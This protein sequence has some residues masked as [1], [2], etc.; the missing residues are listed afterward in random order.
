[1]RGDVDGDPAEQLAVQRDAQ[2][3]GGH[4]AG[5]DEGGAETPGGSVDRVT[6]QP[7]IGT[8]GERGCG[9]RT[10]ARRRRQIE[11]VRGIGPRGLTGR[12]AERHDRPV[13]VDDG[14]D[15]RGQVLR[16]LV[17]RRKAP[18]RAG[19][20]EQGLRRLGL[21]AGLDDGGLGIEGRRGEPGVGL[22]HGTLA[23][24]ERVELGAYGNQVPVVA[25]LRGDVGDEDVL[26]RFGRRLAKR[27][28][29]C[30]PFGLVET[31]GTYETM[32]GGARLDVENELRG[33]D[34]PRG[35][36][37]DPGEHM[38][39]P[40]TR[41][42]FRHRALQFG[43]SG[44]EKPDLHFG[45]PRLRFA[46]LRGV[47]TKAGGAAGIAVGLARLMA[48]VGHREAEELGQRGGHAQPE[49]A[50]LTE[51]LVRR[52]HP[53]LHTALVGP[54]LL[55]R[56]RERRCVEIEEV[57]AA[58]RRPRPESPGPATAPA[59]PVSGWRRRRTGRL[60]SRFPVRLPGRRRPTRAG[61]GAP[62]TESTQP[63]RCSSAAVPRHLDETV[64][65]VQRPLRGVP[66]QIFDEKLRERVTRVPFSGTETASSFPVITMDP[67]H[68]SCGEN[69]QCQVGSKAPGPPGSARTVAGR[70]GQ[71]VSATSL[72]YRPLR[73]QRDGPVV[74]KEYFAFPLPFSQF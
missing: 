48:D 73:L 12:Q 3:A 70:A 27:P 38:L 51:R 58:L 29:H 23:R 9:D 53:Y 26:P 21:A 33:L 1:M 67:L 34:R 36:G 32:G 45:A 10:Q 65:L 18:E 2:G 40:V 43:Q 11:P 25:P 41:P 61:C 49:R 39:Q 17:A 16:H 62:R 72:K 63:R 24:L 64:D 14:G 30:G 28:G 6:V 44:L 15:D 59:S 68:S 54:Q 47:P 74:A 35:P 56:H 46:P 60:R 7:R 66:L 4:G 5:G 20:G 22:E 57:R 71:G 50:E 8:P 19:E 52:A 69:D 13:A 31:L 37:H 55:R 42:Q